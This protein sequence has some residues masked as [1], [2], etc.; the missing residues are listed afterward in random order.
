MVKIK[1]G[2]AG[3]VKRL[4][5]EMDRSKGGNVWIKNVREGE[6]M[7]VR[8]LTE[9]DEWY[10]YR[11]HY[12]PSVNFFPCIGKDADCPGCSHESEKVQR[13]S[14]RYLANALDVEAGAVIPLKLPLDLANRLVARYER[15]GGTI[16]NR[17]YTLHRMGTG[18][19]TT[20]DVTPEDKVDLDLSEYQDKLHDL[21]KALITQFEDAFGLDSGEEPEE[22]PAPAK[23]AA[24]KR[25]P[26]PELDTE[27]DEDDEVPSEPSASSE[28]DGE[29]GYL[30]EEQALQ[31]TK[32]QLKTLASQL[33]IE[34]DGRWS[35]E[36][37][38]ETIFENAG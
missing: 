5:K 21:E 18:L 14:R 30:T 29:E 6:D 7:T 16:L 12:D 26:E 32:V 4:K 3:S 15:N 34:L 35:K 31:M 25:A 36:K 23:K 37:M 1:G 28:E 20:Y 19:D 13:S 38:V 8:F 11:E 27:D 9:P 22:Q 2:K 17:D 24:R 33:N 10:A